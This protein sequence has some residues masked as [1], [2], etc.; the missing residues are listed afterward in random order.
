MVI[1]ARLHPSV[2]LLVQH[3]CSRHS[4]GHREHGQAS[5]RVPHYRVTATHREDKPCTPLPPPQRA[6]HPNSQPRAP[7]RQEAPAHTTESCYL[8]LGAVTTAKPPPTTPQTLSN[9]RLLP[10][11]ARAAPCSSHSSG[12]ADP[13]SHASPALFA[14]NTS[15]M[16][17]VPCSE[18]Q[19]HRLVIG[20]LPPPSSLMSPLSAASPA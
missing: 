17:R 11:R 1:H 19:P 14:T 9:I 6:F 13:H 3:G 16:Q 4:Q 20:G 12:S 2:C 7:P 15:L 8:Q 18:T 5:L 10:S